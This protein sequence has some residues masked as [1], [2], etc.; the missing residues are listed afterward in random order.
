MLA[1]EIM[2]FQRE[3][4]HMDLGKTLVL[5]YSRTVSGFILFCDEFKNYEL[6]CWKKFQDRIAFRL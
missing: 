1:V 6:I 2:R 5:S 4:N 3:K